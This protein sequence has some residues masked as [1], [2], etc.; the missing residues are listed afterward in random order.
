MQIDLQTHNYDSILGTFLV[1]AVDEQLKIAAASKQ[2]QQQP[3]KHKS[4]SFEEA[5]YHISG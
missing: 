5:S 3:V 4:Y 2:Q 1:L